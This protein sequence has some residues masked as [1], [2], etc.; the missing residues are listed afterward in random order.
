MQDKSLTPE[1]QAKKVALSSQHEKD[2]K[3]DGE[4]VCNRLAKPSQYLSNTN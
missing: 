1:E 4:P 3:R 2:Y